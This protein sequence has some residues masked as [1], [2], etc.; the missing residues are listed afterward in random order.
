MLPSADPD[1]WYGSG[2]ANM[3]DR[4]PLSE[5]RAW[6]HPGATYGYDSATLYAPELDLAI[7]V[8]TGVERPLQDQPYDVLCSVYAAVAAVA[9]GASNSEATRAADSCVLS[10]AT[11]WTTKCNCSAL[12]RSY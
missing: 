1:N 11:F 2:T 12:A 8:A 4:L 7:A 6:G 9:R 10:I 5:G 3:T